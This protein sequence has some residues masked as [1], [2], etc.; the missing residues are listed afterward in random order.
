MISLLQ[1]IWSPSQTILSMLEGTTYFS[2]LRRDGYGGTMIIINNHH[3]K[4]LNMPIQIN[5]DS[6]ILKINVGGDRNLWIMSLYINKRSRKN[7]LNCLAEVQ[8]VV[9]QKER[10]YLLIGGDWN[11]NIQDKDDKV[12]QTLSIVC[13]N[14]GL[15]IASCNCLRGQNELDFFIHGGQIKIQEKGILETDLSDHNS[16]WIKLKTD[17]PPYS[18]RHTIIPNRKLADKITQL[19]LYKR[20]NGTEFL[21][22][23]GKKYKYNKLKL[24]KKLRPKPKNN[25]ILNRVLNSNEDDDTF[26]IVKEYWREKAEEC[27]NDLLDG[28]LN[29]AFNFLKAITKYHEFKRRD[30]SII[31]KVKKSRWINSNR[32]KFSQ[33][34]RTI[35]SKDSTDFPNRT[36][37]CN[38]NTFPIT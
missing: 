20:R 21:E 17:A 1:E 18:I 35:T 30:G 2:K 10:P 34:T 28:R 13:K 26:N 32:P 9:P 4:A 3:V 29:K 33:Q 31:N 12:T 16:A 11:I 6:E 22:L 24:E 37:I 5:E 36:H 15:I 8:K 7:L 14:M 23:L 38:S 27:E 25:E 19:C